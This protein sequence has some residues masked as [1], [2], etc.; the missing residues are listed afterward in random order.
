MSDLYALGYT[1]LREVDFHP[2][3]GQEFYVTLGRHGKGPDKSRLEILK[4]I[5][6]EISD[7][8]ARSRLRWLARMLAPPWKA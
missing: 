6:D 1:R 4:A 8:D 2:T 3:E 7:V 5:E